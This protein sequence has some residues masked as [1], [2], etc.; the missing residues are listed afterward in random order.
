LAPVLLL[1]DNDLLHGF[2]LDRQ[3]LFY[4][5]VELS[6]L[7]E[8]G[9]WSP[10][11]QLS[12][13]ATAVA[14]AASGQE[15][16]LAYVRPLPSAELPTGVYYRNWRDGSWG[17]ATLIY[18]S[19]YL[20][21]S[22]EEPLQLD[23]AVAT[24]NSVFVAWDNRLLDLIQM[25]HS[26]NG[27]DTWEEPTIVDARKPGDDLGAPG[28]RNVQIANIRGELHLSWIA[29]QDGGKC[30]L[31]H[32]SSAN[33]GRTWETPQSVFE[34]RQ[35]CPTSRHFIDR[36]SG[37]LMMLLTLR[38]E[39][40]LLA[41]NGAQWSLPESQ[42]SLTSFSHP[43]T[44]RPVTLG[45]LQP[46]AVGE[47]QLAI[48]GCGTGSTTDVWLRQRAGIE[49]ASAWSF[50]GASIWG[51][52]TTALEL[53]AQPLWP[54]LSSDGQ[55]LHLLWSQKR[56]ETTVADSAINYSRWNGTTWSR[57]LVLPRSPSGQ[58]SEPA[59]VFDKDR[60][61]L[62]IIWRD[63]Q[64]GELYFSHADA[65]LANSLAEWNRPI[66]LPKPENTAVGSPSL[67]VDHAGIYYAAFV[68][69]LNE[70]RGVYLLQSTDQGV[71]WSE[72]IS[73]FAAGAA[74][75]DMVG[76][77][78]F[79]G[80]EDGTLHLMWSEYTLPPDAQPI[81]LYYARSED[82]G[83]NWSTAAL[84][85][86][87]G[88]NWSQLLAANGIAHRLWQEP[89]DNA[90]I[91][92]QLSLDNG[93]NWEPPVLISAEGTLVEHPAVVLDRTGRI[94]LVQIQRDASGQANLQHL[95]WQ[96]GQWLTDDTLRLQESLEGD[97]TKMLIAIIAMEEQY[98]QLTAVYL[99][100]SPGNGQSQTIPQ[101]RF[102]LTQRP[103]EVPATSFTLPSPQ[104]SPTVTL[105]AIATPLPTVTPTPTAIL[106]SP[107]V[108]RASFQ[109]GP[110]N[111]QSQEGVLL[112]SIIPAAFVILLVFGFA[113]YF[114]R[115]RN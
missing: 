76:S 115:L 50:A 104:I 83:L 96:E 8:P 84:V 7:A 103:I 59:M 82:G 112:L 64:L 20:R 18:Q 99:D 108:E 12:A 73:V 32:Q 72:P 70:E 31:Y 102:V 69:A 26:R 74:N 67:F 39:A 63:D 33:N 9:A 85:V 43:Q 40:Y 28:P 93:R 53:T 62:L 51:M 19:D 36:Q 90:P 68:V 109:L 77:L 13:S 91:W 60:R 24:N 92:H 113:I 94:H 44:Y 98:H 34:D 1:D 2:W 21:A 48:L 52:P 37:L 22:I 3:R 79:A 71:S 65:A 56:G 10:P 14:V 54:S 101:N 80:S 114:S 41:W 105:A 38:D 23:I 11:Q 81:G 35:D 57:P 58:V 47:T 106:L 55:H 42:R 61:R 66:A 89:G 100:L 75:W 30:I 88:V 111:T 45:C 97:S 49:D 78:S 87:N 6:E 46:V 27:G 86:N 25:T 110:L 29:R 107:D 5:N 17:N 4:S 15:V 95:L 16:H